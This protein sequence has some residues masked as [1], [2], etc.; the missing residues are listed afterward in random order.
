[1]LTEVA[2]GSPA[3]KAGLRVGDVLLRFGGVVPT[4]GRHLQ[5]LII[6]APIDSAVPILLRRGGQDLTIPVS[7]AAWPPQDYAKVNGGPAAQPPMT[8]RRDL[9][10]T[11]GAITD[12][13]RA[14]NGLRPGQTG[15]LVT[16]VMAGT[17]A[18]LRGIGSGDV[19]MRVQDAV[20]KNGADVQREVDKVRALGRKF[21]LFL[22]RKK[23]SD[24]SGPRWLAL[25]ISTDG[26]ASVVAKNGK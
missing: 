7:V 9:G 10:L 13:A 16:G 20:V 11:F 26:G 19:I 25:R 14:R 24:A 23:D 5:R 15:V 2:A 6:A 4:D 1:M 12:E 17:D 8:A 21:A 18:W 3:A 22:V